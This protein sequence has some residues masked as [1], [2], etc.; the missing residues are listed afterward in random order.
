MEKYLKLWITTP[1][2]TASTYLQQTI[3]Q[4]YH[5]EK[6]YRTHIAQECP[7]DPENWNRIINVRH[8]K[9]AATMSMLVYHMKEPSNISTD[10]YLKGLHAQYNY[11]IELPTYPWN[12]SHV[13]YMEDFIK[14][15]SGLENKLPSKWPKLNEVWQITNHEKFLSKRKIKDWCFNWSELFEIGQIVEKEGHYK[16]YQIVKDP[17]DPRFST[18]R[19]PNIFW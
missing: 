16:G 1:S 4:N 14:N 18:K 15:P 19:R 17:E 8:D 9:H 10:E 13:I 5:I 11:I 7:L 6:I 3:E 12:S 2:R